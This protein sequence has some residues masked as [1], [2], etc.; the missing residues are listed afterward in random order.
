MTTWGLNGSDWVICH[1]WQVVKNEVTMQ[2]LKWTVTPHKSKKSYKMNVIDQPKG[3]GDR[4]EESEA[5]MGGPSAKQIIG[6]PKAE[7]SG[8]QKGG[9]KW[10]IKRG[11]G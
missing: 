9:E 4:E 3:G 7:F 10:E 5:K 11:K 2:I 8:S 1:E 6:V